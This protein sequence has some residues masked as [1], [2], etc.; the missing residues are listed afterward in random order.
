MLRAT[1]MIALNDLRGALWLRARDFLA[2]YIKAS[3]RD[4][5]RA[6]Y[7]ALLLS[8]PIYYYS[9]TDGTTLYDTAHLVSFKWLVHTTSTVVIIIRS[10]QVLVDFIGSCIICIV[11]RLHHDDILAIDYDI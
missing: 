7:H 1:W 9:I 2:C 3:A 4:S 8:L 5:R 11:R 10:Q 6:L